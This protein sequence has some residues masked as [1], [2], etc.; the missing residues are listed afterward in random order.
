MSQDPFVQP[1]DAPAA[2]AAPAE[3]RAAGAENLAASVAAAVEKL[4][5]DTVRCT[6]VSGDRYRCN[7]W[8]AQ[9]VLGYD[10][11]GMRGL[12]V[13]THRVRKSLFLR[14][15]RTAAGLAIRVDAA[16]RTTDRLSN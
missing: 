3:R 6:H 5:G 15:S 1:G 9:S 14:A 12:M 7:W 11:P 16:C 8:S 2:A 10:N 13:T 4:P